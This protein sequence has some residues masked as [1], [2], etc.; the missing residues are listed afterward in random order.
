MQRNMKQ[1]YHSNAVTNLH[2][3][4]QIKDSNSTNL[5]LTNRHNTSEIAISKW[6]FINTSDFLRVKPKK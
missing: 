3:R 4:S 1:G 5:E 6:K 2:I